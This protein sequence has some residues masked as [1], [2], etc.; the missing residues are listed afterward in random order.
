MAVNIIQNT[1]RSFVVRLVVKSTQVPVDLTGLIGDQ[2]IVKMDGEDAPILIEE[3]SGVEIL[4][5][6]AGKFK[7]TLNESQTNALKA[8]DGQSL[9]VVIRRGSGPD[10]DTSV[11]QIPNSI[12]VKPRIYEIAP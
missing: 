4:S 1:D 2:L 7:V 12:N 8:R 5:G 3:G 6:I 9:E 11:V 10:Y